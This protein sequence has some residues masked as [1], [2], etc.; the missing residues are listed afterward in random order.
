MKKINQILLEQ[1]KI[2]KPDKETSDKISDSANKIVKELNSKLKS[3]KIKAE[4]FIGGSLAKNTMVKKDKYD[5]DIFVR[6]DNKYEDKEISKL[7]GGVLGKKVKKIHGSR[8][9]YQTVVNG[10]IMEIIPVLNIKKPEEAKNITD[11][12][13]FHVH[14]LLKQIR[15]NKK[16]CDEILLAKTFAYANDCYGAESYIRGFSGYALE[17]LIS[18]YKSFLRFIKEISKISISSQDNML[19][20][21]RLSSKSDK[22]LIN[23]I[24]IDQE[25]L[26]KNKNQIMLELN[27]SKK[28]S[29]IILI[30]PTFKDRNALAG[31]SQDT[32][33]K[34]QKVCKAF[35]SKPNKSF[36][37]KKD[38]GGELTKKYGKK[39]IIISVK[40][41]K[42]A[43][44]IAG[45]KSKKFFKFFCRK[46]QREFQIQ[47]AEFDYDEKKNIAYFYFVLNK[48]KDEIVQ[49][50]PVT[51]VQNLAR[52]KKAHPKAF[53]KNHIAYAKIKHNL[54]LKSFVKLFRHSE[55]RVLRQ[56]SISR[57]IVLK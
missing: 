21:M 44:D 26:Y 34:F 23:K 55:S 51:A 16:L 3:K 33:Q 1:L 29:P 2:I 37:E 35:L 18:H 11:L 20:K 39:L 41:N 57:L 56:M 14:Y 48:K 7:L 28:Q 36:F 12:S 31:L 32:F 17:L 4:V 38:I 47:L 46:L 25:K 8:D 19:K 5:V 15:K 22:L 30:D 53:I 13:Y 10:I 40:T 54:D 9:Y 50:P 27:K 43:G 6:F 42:Q 49:G 24:I 45:S 52:F